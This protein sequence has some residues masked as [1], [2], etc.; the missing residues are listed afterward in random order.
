VLV[1]LVS[2]IVCHCLFRLCLTALTAVAGAVLMM[3][4]VLMLLNT[5]AGLDAPGLAERAPK[6]LN[7]VGGLLALAGFA[8]QLY[9]HRRAARKQEGGEEKREWTL[10]IPRV[11]EWVAT[12]NSDAA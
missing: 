12:G 1:F 9:L 6:L 3:S 10:R 5:Y 8:L 4:A 11:W 7:W 2:G